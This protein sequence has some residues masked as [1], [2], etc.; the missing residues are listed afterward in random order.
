MAREIIRDDTERNAENNKTDSSQ[1]R[2][3][4]SP[5]LDKSN[6]RFSPALRRNYTIPIIVACVVIALLGWLLWSRSSS[7]PSAVA[8]ENKATTNNEVVLSPEAVKTAGIEIEEVKRRPAVALMRVTGMVE[9]NQQQTQQATPLVTG[10]IERVNVALGDRVSAGMALAVI[11]SPEI[12]EMHGKLHESET[13]Y[14]LAQRNLTRVER[15]ENRVSVLQAKA[16]LDEADATLKRT[17]RLVE[18][19]AG[20]GKDLIAAETA[21]SSAKAEYDFQS[22]ISLNR[23]LQE[24][25]AAVE[26]T[27][28]DVAHIRDQL[29]ALGA[30]VPEGERDDHSKD[31]SLVAV[32]A[33]VSGTVTERLV[34]A[35]AG[36]QAGTPLFTI[37]NISTV[38]VVANVPEAQVNMLRPGTP[39]EV[40]SA[41]LGLDGIAGRVSYI[42]PQLNEEMRTARVRINVANPRERLKVGMFAEVRFQAGMGVASNSASGEE[43]MVAT[44]AVHRIGE[45][46]IVFIPKEGQAGHYEVHDVQ[47]GGETEGYQRVLSGLNA[48]DRVVTKGSF[49]LKTRLLRGEL[50]E[51]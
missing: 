10:R 27:R 23:E 31:T 6:A 5:E 38:W 17:R 26:T 51:E 47:V 18:L 3:H 37:A 40:H 48:G 7:K 12:A 32:R 34:N 8:K 21:Y 13:R 46:T 35:G 14:E 36:I 15:T 50:Q 28:V 29:R 30:P 49:T 20:A 24:A 42:D 2:E 25:R 43:L 1:N 22:N 11:S 9:A 16:K 45:R 33:P 4:A 19:G 44:T 39:A 41:A